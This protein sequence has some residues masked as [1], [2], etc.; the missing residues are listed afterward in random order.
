[1]KQLKYLV[2]TLLSILVTSMAQ[3]TD[4]TVQA[5]GTRTAL[6]GTAAVYST[7]SVFQLK[8]GAVD[9]KIDARQPATRVEGGYNYSLVGPV[10]LRGGVG[11]QLG[12]STGKWYYE[13]GVGVSDY[14]VYGKI[15]GSLGYN[16]RHSL[17]KVN[18]DTGRIW[19]VGVGY[20]LLPAT[21][22]RV[23][24]ESTQGITPQKSALVGLTQSF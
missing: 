18:T 1:M 8:D 9:F 19:N 4:L 5:S 24:F 11:T 20:K 22:L 12:S 21:T 13:A 3:A 15:V 10:A 2:F 14:P 17:N 7:G 16:F 6:P 23:G